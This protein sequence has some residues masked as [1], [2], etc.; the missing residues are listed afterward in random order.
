MCEPSAAA[1]AALAAAARVSPMRSV[2]A[3]QRHSIFDGLNK[4]KAKTAQA[5]SEGRHIPTTAERMAEMDAAARQSAARRPGPGRP[6][7]EGARAAEHW[8][9]VSPVCFHVN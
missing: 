2:A 4:M 1:L 7:K 6:R 8:F 5:A 9:A 3:P